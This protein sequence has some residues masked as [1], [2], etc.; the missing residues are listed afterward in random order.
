MALSS[1][2]PLWAMHQNPLTRSSPVVQVGGVLPGGISVRGLSGGQKRRLSIACA[3]LARPSMLFL[4]EPTTGLDS[5]AAL[6]V[7]TALLQEERGQSCSHE[8]AC[9]QWGVC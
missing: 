4:D 7:R 8:A 9:E 1:P 3:L 5:H 6:T 2:Q